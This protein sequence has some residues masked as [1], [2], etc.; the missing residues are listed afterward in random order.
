MPRSAA[1]LLREAGMDALHVGE[2]GMACAADTEII[3]VAKAEERVVVTLDADFHTLLAL[4]GVGKPS[5]VRIRLEGLKG[6]EMTRLILHVIRMTM[7][8]LVSGAAVVV[9]ENNIRIKRLPIA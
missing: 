9:T 3:A 1:I 5:V 4:S 2:I 8:Q 6:G 7:D